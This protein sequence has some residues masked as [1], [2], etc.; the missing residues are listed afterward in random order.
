MRRHLP[1]ALTLVVLSSA[2]GVL[3]AVWG[4]S[5]TATNLAALGVVIVSMIVFALTAVPGSP[6]QRRA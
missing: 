3:Q 6:P 5:N 4:W 2:V 1:T